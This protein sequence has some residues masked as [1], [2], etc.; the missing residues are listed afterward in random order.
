DEIEK[1]L[2]RMRIEAGVEEDLK[3]LR[4]ELG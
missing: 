1:E 4:E 3:R 2:E